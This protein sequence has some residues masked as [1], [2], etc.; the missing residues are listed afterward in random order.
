M[1]SAPRQAE[2]RL[3]VISIGIAVGYVVA[4]AMLLGAHGWI[5]DAQGRPGLTDFVAVWS[6]GS[7]A[8][9]GAAA[10]AYDGAAQHAAEVAAMG[11]GFAGQLGWPYPPCFLFVA[12]T[13]ARLPYGWAF[14][15]WTCVSLGLQGWSIAAVTRRRLGVIVAFA[16]PWTLACVMVGQNGLVTAALIGAVLLTAQK[17]PVLCGVLLGLLTYKPQFGLLFPIA[18]AMNGRW[19]VLSWAALTTLALTALSVEAFGL[20]SLLGFIQGLPRT[21]QSLVS[22]GAVGWNKLQSMYGLV[23]CLGGSNPLGWAAQMVMTTGT[24][25]AIGALWRGSAPFEV[26]AASLAV[27][28]VLATP[29]VF[30]YDLPVLG[31][32][33]AFLYRQRGFDRLDYVLL[34][35][36]ALILPP[37]MFVS[38]PLGFVES[39]LVATMVARRAPALAGVPP[40]WV[41]GRAARADLGL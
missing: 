20:D 18:L 8:L 33:V 35:V 28:A 24:A 30:A 19:R 22:H 29:Y 12:E 26:K 13:L 1:A 15:L 9:K 4:F 32:A 11:H 37:V 38:L 21:T 10:A 25:A 31:I 41:H 36:T 5:L 23:R 6:A 40:M 14:G 2:A 16:A 3:V 17:R 34:A 27:A 7:L 39:L